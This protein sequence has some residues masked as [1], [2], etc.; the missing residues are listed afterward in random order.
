M[1][2]T[3]ANNYFRNGGVSVLDE[4]TLQ[5]KLN[6]ASKYFINFLSYYPKA[7]SPKAIIDHIPSNYTT[8][9]S[10]NLW[11]MVSLRTEFPNLQ[12]WTKLGLEPNHDPAIS[13]LVPQ[14]D[15]R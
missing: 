10:D 14:A 11:G 6:Y 7:L 2:V 12:D 15:Y 8:N 5:I 1:N 9:Q 13:G 4:Y 3:Q